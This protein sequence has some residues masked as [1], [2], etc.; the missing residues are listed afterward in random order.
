MLIDPG[1]GG[2]DPG[3][4]GSFGVPGKDVPLAL[5]DLIKDKLEEEEASVRLVLTRTEDRCAALENGLTLAG[6]TAGKQD[7]AYIPSDLVQTR[8]EGESLLLARAV[9][10]GLVRYL[11]GRWQNVS[12]LGVKKGPFYVMV[13]A[14]MPRVLVEVGFLTHPVEGPRMGTHRYRR[15]VAEGVAEGIR[16]FLA[17]PPPGTTL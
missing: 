17:A 9:Q 4:E 12:D 6:A 13:G 3:A 5:A 15:D 11:R 16:R 1:H 2:K 7:L 8:K 14:C 10:N